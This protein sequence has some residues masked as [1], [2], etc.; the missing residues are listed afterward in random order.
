MVISKLKSLL[1]IEFSLYFG[2]RIFS[3]SLSFESCWKEILLFFFIERYLNTSSL[4][5]KT[6]NPLKFTVNISIFVLLDITITIA[7]LEKKK[8]LKNNKSN[9]IKNNVPVH[10]Y[11]LVRDWR[12]D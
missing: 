8:K 12:E 1:Y 10:R 7:P 11:V 4:K 6:L 3:F 5:L 9:V 2:H